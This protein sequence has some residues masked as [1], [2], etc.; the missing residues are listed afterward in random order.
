M[1][2]SATSVGPARLRS[3]LDRPSWSESLNCPTWKGNTFTHRSHPKGSSLRATRGPS[4]LAAT[5]WTLAELFA[6]IEHFCFNYWNQK[7]HADLGKSPAQALK[8]LVARHGID[9]I[10][11]ERFDDDFLIQTMP[12][13][14]RGTTCV[15]KPCGVFFRGDYY[16]NPALAVF[17]GK[18]L[19]TRWDPMDPSRVFV[20]LPDGWVA[21]FS[22]F[23]KE[24]AG[25]SVRD[26]Q[27][28]A[29]D[30]R[31]RHAASDQ[32]H[33]RSD[34]ELGDYLRYLKEI[35]EP[36][37]RARRDRARENHSVNSRLMGKTGAP[38]DA[39]ETAATDSHLGPPAPQPVTPP[40]PATPPIQ[41]TAPSTP[42]V[43]PI[44]R[45]KAPNVL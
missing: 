11:G 41:P 26:V 43:L 31:N 29:Q 21:C 17:I 27:F 44:V 1:S 10:P 32:D 15:Q 4:W 35:Q 23:T 12:E 36:E 37:L 42:S 13:V 9:Q 18:D 14:P 16:H 25:L 20:Q 39:T 33:L 22:K 28:F 24:V 8:E 34:T 6:G 3:P 45:R 2:G 40:V 30:L 19:P 38:A 5:V 7:T